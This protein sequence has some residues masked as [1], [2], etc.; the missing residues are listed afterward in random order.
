MENGSPSNEMEN[1]QT[2]GG[3]GLENQILE[4]L[5]TRTE[6]PVQAF[7]ILQQLSVFLWTRYDIDWKNDG[8]KVVADTPEDRYLDYMKELIR[9]FLAVK[10]Q[11]P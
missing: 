6:S 5:R 10:A 2:S 8:E 3:P 4:M 11:Q 9:H 7:T 1:M